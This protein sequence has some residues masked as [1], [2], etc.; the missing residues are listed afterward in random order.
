[1]FSPPL[2]APPPLPMKVEARVE[3][4]LRQLPAV[5]SVPAPTAPTTPLAPATPGTREPGAR[6]RGRGVA[7]VGGRSE[8]EGGPIV[9][10]KHQT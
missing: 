1:M 6:A 5:A 7:Q 2:Q 8:P 9:E 10:H 4:V 3:S